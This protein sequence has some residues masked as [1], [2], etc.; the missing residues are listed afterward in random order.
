MRQDAENQRRETSKAN[1]T[2]TLSLTA[3]MHE[4]SAKNLI[5]GASPNNFSPHQSPKTN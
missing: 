3:S 4:K 1:P 5:V 2:R